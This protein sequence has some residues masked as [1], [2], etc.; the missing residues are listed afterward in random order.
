MKNFI[1][2]NWIIILVWVVILALAFTAIVVICK[3][4]SKISSLQREN[5]VLTREYRTLAYRD[6]LLMEDYQALYLE[7]S[8]CKSS[9]KELALAC[10]ALRNKCDSLQA[11]KVQRVVNPPKSRTTNPRSTRTRTGSYP[12]L[13]W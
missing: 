9:N 12:A 1:K 3:K 8:I 4:E 2:R 7:D 11:R 6:S 10:E 13:D 5:A